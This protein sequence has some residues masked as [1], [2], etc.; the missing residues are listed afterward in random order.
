VEVWGNCVHLL[1]GKGD[2]KGVNIYHEHTMCQ[3]AHD[4]L[5]RL[6][7]VLMAKCATLWGRVPGIKF[8][9]L[10]WGPWTDSLISLPDRIGTT[11]V[12]MHRIFCHLDEFHTTCG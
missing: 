7:H 1:L 10:H 5:Q 11:P 3:D 9:L 2:G 8:Q 6:K 4:E 12:P